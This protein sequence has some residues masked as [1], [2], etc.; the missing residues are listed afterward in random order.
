MKFA[1]PFLIVLGLAGCGA[2][3]EPVTPNLAASVSVGPNG[4]STNAG[5]RVRKGPFTLGWNLF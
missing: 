5:V 4:L 3:G 2:D 1:V